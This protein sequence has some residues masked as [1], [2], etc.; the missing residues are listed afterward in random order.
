[1]QASLRRLTAAA[2]IALT[3]V[4]A[5]AATV[6]LSPNNPSGPYGGVFGANGFAGV[7]IT[8]IVN[9]TRTYNGVGGGFNLFG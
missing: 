2:L 3:P 5:S 4:L 8:S 1:M 6:T 9:P 7:S